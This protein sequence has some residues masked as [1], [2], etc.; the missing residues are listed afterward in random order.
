MTKDSVL[1][2]VPSYRWRQRA[3]RSL[4]R[5]L[6]R[7]DSPLWEFRR[8]FPDHPDLVWYDKTSKKF[9]EELDLIKNY[10]ESFTTFPAVP[11]VRMIYLN[12]KRQVRS[13]LS[14]PDDWLSRREALHG[15]IRELV[16]KNS[17]LESS[18]VEAKEQLK[19]ASG[20]R[21][22]S[23]SSFNEEYLRQDVLVLVDSVRKRFGDIPIPSD[24]YKFA[25]GSPLSVVYRHEGCV[26]LET[27]SSASLIK[28]LKEI[29]SEKESEIKDIRDIS[30]QAE[31]DITIGINREIS[32]LAPLLS[33]N[34]AKF[35]IMTKVMMGLVLIGGCTADW[36]HGIQAD[37]T[38]VEL[39]TFCSQKGYFGAELTALFLAFA[40]L[41]FSLASFCI[42]KLSTEAWHDSPQKSEETK[43]LV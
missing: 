31:E 12:S 2:F 17:F 32:K 19:T 28:R 35:P 36:I 14:E 11:G 10:A 40:L 16:E 33:R 5:V 42:M 21:N 15:T 22:S 39:D 7:F 8:D 25:D 37:C 20:A 24:L 1:R 23:P 6:N 4:K 3:W 27:P 13:E 9:W 38:T 43:L 18:L 26:P 29:I 30:F 34:R 41:I